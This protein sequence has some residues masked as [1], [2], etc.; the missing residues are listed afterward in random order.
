MD[1]QE[2]T[3][4]GYDATAAAYAARFH[5]LLDRRPVE[6]AMLSAFAGLVP[7]SGLRDVAD[8]GCGT[9][10]TTA[11][12][13]RLGLT[14]MGI[15]LSPNMV[16]EAR[17]RNPDL[18]FSVGTMTALE[19][20]DASVGGVCAWYSTI[21][22]PDADLPVALS[23]FERVLVAGGAVLLAFQVGEGSRRL[24]EAFG[25]SVDLEFRRRQPGEVSAALVAAGLTPYSTTV[26]E[27]DADIESDGVAALPQ[28]FVLARK[29]DLDR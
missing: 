16:D 29:P 26:R 18:P 9:G 23:E 27:A 22:V 6:R 2:R 13:A 17:R 3:R 15:D 21:H 11:H 8:V 7:R 25:S 20:G 19:L 10:A 5:D 24:S 12:L 28:A 4:A 14:P 1:Y